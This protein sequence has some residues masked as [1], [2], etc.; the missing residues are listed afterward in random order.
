MK[1]AEL[2]ARGFAVATLDVYDASA[3]RPA[4]RRQVEIRCKVCRAA[5]GF[6]AG[7]ELSAAAALRL[8][9]HARSHD[10]VSP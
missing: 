9:D 8:L 6:P 3:P 4:R 5:W 1:L 10:E 7:K 2:R